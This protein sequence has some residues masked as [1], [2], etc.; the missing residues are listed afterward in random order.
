MAY[1]VYLRVTTGV[2]LAGFSRTDHGTLGQPIDDGRIVATSLVCGGLIV[3]GVRWTPGCQGDND[4]TTRGAIG[5]ARTVSGHSHRT[6]LVASKNR[7]G[8]FT[9]GKRP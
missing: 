5:V 8:T 9:I 7:L 4:S 2:E 3:G 6:G 1:Y